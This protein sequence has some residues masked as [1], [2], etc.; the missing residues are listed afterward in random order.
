MRSTRA[1]NTFYMY[2]EIT[3]YAK[4]CPS[5]RIMQ[6]TNELN[7]DFFVS[8]NFHLFKTYFNCILIS[9]N[10]I[11]CILICYIYLYLTFIFKYE[12][13]FLC[14]SFVIGPGPFKII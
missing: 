2:T 14:T 13:L 1:R 3:N 9:H 11:K 5:N 6:F 7:I 10:Y 12:R 4:N 8:L